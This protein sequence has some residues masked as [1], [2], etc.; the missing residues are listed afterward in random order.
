MKFNRPLF[1]NEINLISIL[2]YPLSLITFLI[3][4]IKKISTKR[5][6]KIKSICVGNLYVGGTGKTPLSIKINNILKKKYKTVF[7]KKEYSDQIDEQNILKSYG[8]LIC[9][10]DRD[11]A[12][13]IATKQKYDVAIL[14]DGLQDKSL[15]YNI[16]IACFNSS[17]GIGNSFLI[18]SG[19]LREDI[20][21]IKN[22][23]AVFLNGE[24]S[25]KEFSK[26]LKKL[27]NDIKVFEAKYTPTNLRSF[28]LK[29][30]ILFFCGMGNPSEFE[31]TLKKYKFKIKEKF[32]YPDH[33]NFSNFDILNLKK[34]AKNKKLNIITTEKD[35]LR[36]NKKNK[37][38]V[39]FLKIDLSI[40]NMQN[41]SKFLFETL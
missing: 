35:Y 27:N 28:N 29:K 8:N 14:D 22:Y 20:S 39:K 38:N 15:N 31:R 40:K 19:P 12:L 6:F 11:N 5:N 4:I 24:K 21:E 1:W 33:Y 23:D 3:N 25:N 7:I 13:K 34:L 30:K 32:I 36:L 41:F 10:K 16:T 9:R 17:D 18:P 2:L 26:Y 37:K